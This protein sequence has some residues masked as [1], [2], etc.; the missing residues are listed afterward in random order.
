MN[1][2]KIDFDGI[3]WASVAT[4]M[5]HKTFVHGNQ[6]LRLVELSDEFVEQNGCIFGH[7]AVVLD[8]GFAESTA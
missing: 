8:G 3:E 2:H 1:N 7:A 5:R 4:G 6:R